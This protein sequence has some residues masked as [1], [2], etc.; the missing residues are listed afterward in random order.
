MTYRLH[1]LP[2]FDAGTGGLTLVA[3]VH[4]TRDAKVLPRKLSRFVRTPDGQGLGIIRED[5]TVEV[6]QTSRGGRRISFLTE[7][8]ERECDITLMAVLQG[9]AYVH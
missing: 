7:V 1:A 3:H 5:G 4:E 6:W 9:G 2:F 8:I